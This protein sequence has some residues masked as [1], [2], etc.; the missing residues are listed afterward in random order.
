MTTVLILFS[1]NAGGTSKTGSGTSR[2]Y[3]GGSFY[4]GGARTPYTAGA[5]SPSGITP[6]LVGGVAL[7]FALG[8]W[9]FPLY[10]YPY[11]VPYTYHHP[12]NQSES[13]NEGNY[14]LNVVCL[15]EQYQT[16]GCDGNTNQTY[17]NEIIGDPPHNSSAVTVMKNGTNETAYINGTLANGTTAAD[18]DSGAARLAM[19]WNGYVPAVAIVSAMV[20]YL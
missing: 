5:R 6:F 2:S 7:G 15:C 4:P 3:G 12:V 18:P 19:Q 13:N 20:W 8:V 1:S 9:A 11:G 10:S 17:L 16:C 14:T